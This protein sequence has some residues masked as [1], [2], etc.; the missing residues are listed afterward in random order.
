[1]VRDNPEKLGNTSYFTELNFTKVEGQDFQ[2]AYTVFNTGLDTDTTMPVGY[3][4]DAKSV[5]GKSLTLFF[6]DYGDHAWGIWCN[7]GCDAGSRF[8]LLDMK[9]RPGG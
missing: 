4:L 5:S 9:N 3:R 6:F 1:M 2:E 7:H 8:M